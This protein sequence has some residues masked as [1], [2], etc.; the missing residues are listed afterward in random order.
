MKSISRSLRASASCAA[1]LR[2]PAAICAVRATSEA[3]CE[4]SRGKGRMRRGLLAC[5]PTEG[6]PTA[7]SALNMR[8]FGPFGPESRYGIASKS[9]SVKPMDPLRKYSQETS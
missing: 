5:Y 8:F 4:R 9:L 1:G 2:P 3:C 7:F 6:A